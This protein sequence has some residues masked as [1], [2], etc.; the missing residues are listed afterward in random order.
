MCAIS[1]SSQ[2]SYNTARRNCD[3]RCL[4]RKRAG[5]APFSIILEYLVGATFG[6]YGLLSTAKHKGYSLSRH[7]AFMVDLT[8]EQEG[9]L[10]YAL[11]H[12]MQIHQAALLPLPGALAAYARAAGRVSWHARVEALS[13]AQRLVCELRKSAVLPIGTPLCHRSF[14]P[15]ES[16]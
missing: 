1:Q 3:Q 12:L 10:A 5:E 2:L 13:S 15:P 9:D 14:E 8:E 11:A 6:A 4:S 7:P 16:P